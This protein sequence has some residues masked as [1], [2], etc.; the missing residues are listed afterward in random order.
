[1]AKR[2]Y[3]N[4]PVHEVI[5]DVQF[6]RTVDEKALRDIRTRLASSFAEVEPLNVMQVQMFTGPSGQT[7]Q[8]SATQFGGWVFKEKD[9]SWVLQT[10]PT[11]L[12]LHAVRPG[13]WPIGS[14]VGWSAIRDRFLEAHRALAD[15]YGQME[16]KRASV[17]YLNRIATPEGE[18]VGKWLTVVP[19]APELLRG[20]YAFEVRQ[21]WAK[22][23]D[24]ERLSATIGLAKIDI[25]DAGVAAGNQGLLL[26]IEVF[27]LWIP[28]AP[29][30]PQLPDWF[31]AAHD[32]ENRIF[33][34]CITNALRERLDNDGSSSEEAKRTDR[35]RP[36][37]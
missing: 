33:E 7:F 27:N 24:D 23:G 8:S 3:R 5:L 16:P 10:G 21:T 12:V 4:P 35:V 15:V 32:V 14:Y 1:V 37:N 30:Y 11:A 34:A 9:Q 26:D 22:V 17:R 19:N 36:A 31:T 18:D 25:P 2:E 20:L 28:N 13:S 6:H 29:S